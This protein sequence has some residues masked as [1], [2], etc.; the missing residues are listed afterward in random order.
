M[1]L[2]PASLAVSGRTYAYYPLSAVP[3]LS[4]ASLARL[5]YSVR[6]LLEALLRKA[7]AGRAVA[8]DLAALA[9]WQPQAAAR[10]PLPVFVG[11]VLLQD[12]SGVPVLNDLAAMRAASARQGG[13]PRRINPV[14][15]VDLIIDHSIQVDF[16]GSEDAFARNTALEFER[17]RERYEFLHWCQQTFDNLRILPPAAG[18][19]HQVNLELLA[20]VA[21]TAE[22]DGQT[23]V[24]PDTVVGT[25]SHT[26]MVNG[27]GVVGWGVGGI[28][29]VAAML[30]EPVEILQPD[31]IG[32]RL[33]GHLR[34]GVTPTDLTLTVTQLLRKFG[35]VDKFIE[36]IGP[37]VETLTLASR[38]ML[39]NMAPE[40]GATLLYFPVD[41]RTLDYLRLTGRSAEQI[42]LVEAYYRA[43]G[44]FRTAE[45]PE[46]D[47][48]AVLE[49]DLASVEPSLAGPRRPQDRVSLADVSTSFASA[50]TAPRTENGFGVDPAE[51][52]RRVSIQLD[53]GPAV[54]T[55]GSVVLAAITSCTNTS[56]PFVMLGAGLLAKKAVARGLR[57]NPAVKTSLAPGSRVVTEYLRRAGLMEPLETLGF[58]LV[59]YGCTTCIG[60]SGP[61]P[62]PVVQA[63]REQN[64][65]VG[66]V[67]SGNRNFEGRVSPH[68]RANYLASPPLVVAYALAGSLTVDLTRDPIG[69]DP[70]GRAV[71]LR[72]IWPTS[73]EIEQAL[74]ASLDAALFRAA[75]QHLDQS[76]PAWNAIPARPGLLYDWQADSTYL[77]EPPFFEDAAPIP[78]VLSGARALAWLGDSITTDH[79]S[80]AGSIAVNSPAGQY[81]SGLGVAPAD[82]NAYGTRRGNDRVMTRGTFANVRLKNLLVPGVEGGFTRHLP[83]GE[84]MSIYA[85]AQRYRAEGVPLIILAGKEYG[86]GSSRD[87]AAKGVR[88]LGVR[89]VLAES[90]ERIHRSNLAGMGVLPLQFLPGQN[91]ASLG[92]TGEELFDLALPAALTPGARVSVTARTAAGREIRFETL[93]RLD[94]A[95]E[96]TYLADGGILNTVLKGI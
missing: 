34:E 88:L 44:L 20:G 49:L 6:I 96:L 15:P 19:V 50:L 22:R 87:W 92:L 76:N 18:I 5:P 9:A 51:T 91:A 46:P 12:F 72:D 95:N 10:P 30:G 43:Q 36:F 35:V 26:T 86:T 42:A 3:N 55:H 84:P 93:L 48:T 79:I 31:V 21:L 16:S 52:A 70:A 56:D 67:L 45:S 75:Y 38:A 61:L 68:T 81:L 1:N 7:A 85:A 37:G 47:Y 64:L 8:S 57:V 73:Q 28:E 32:L 2:S 60:N 33:T 25:D 41:D 74:H 82:F 59:G 4:A 69:R 63:V 78:A 13:D 40:S 58:H 89:A 90:Y 62:E 11:R 39:S 27:L 65:V 53:A 29:A 71:Y 77:Q 24:Y 80:P 17:N 54:L 83:D 66:A 14:I 94:T 23:F